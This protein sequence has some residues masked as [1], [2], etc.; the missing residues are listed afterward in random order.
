MHCSCGMP[1]PS[2]VLFQISQDIGS[3]SAEASFQKTDIVLLKF[4]IVGIDVAEYECLPA[5]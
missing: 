2:F 1:V 3:N 4:P 5:S